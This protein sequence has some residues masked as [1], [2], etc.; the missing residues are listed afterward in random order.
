MSRECLTSQK[1]PW[2]G[3]F[4]YSS[5]LGFAVHMWLG[6]PWRPDESEGRIH[7]KP[8]AARLRDRMIFPSH[9]FGTQFTVLQHLAPT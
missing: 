4:P 9:Y 5:T 6:F 3:A 8:R 1:S 2:N 7:K